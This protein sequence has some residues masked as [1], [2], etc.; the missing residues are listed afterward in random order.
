MRRFLGLCF[1]ILAFTAFAAFLGWAL[2]T[3]LTCDVC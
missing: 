2:A 1:D 3:W